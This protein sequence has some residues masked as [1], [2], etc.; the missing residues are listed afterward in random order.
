VTQ[1][2]DAH[3]NILPFKT[4]RPIRSLRL[5]ARPNDVYRFTQN[6]SLIVYPTIDPSKAIAF[7]FTKFSNY[8]DY[9]IPD[10][11]KD[12]ALKGWLDSELEKTIVFVTT[13]YNPLIDIIP[14]INYTDFVPLPIQ[15]WGI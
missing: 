7:R 13:H 2:K 10:V 5:R 15:K 11:S 8:V 14:E 4:T 9:Q 3:T 12:V 1:L 6:F